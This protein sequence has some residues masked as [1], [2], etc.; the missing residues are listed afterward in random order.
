MKRRLISALIGF[1]FLPLVLCGQEITKIGD[2]T[3]K[4]PPPAGFARLDGAN[5]EMDIFLRQLVPPQKRFLMAMAMPREVAKVKD[6][7]P[8][9]VSRSM[10][11]QTPRMTE[12]QKL[13]AEQFADLRKSVETQFKAGD[14]LGA[15]IE[16]QVN[17]IF[18]KAK[19]PGG[20]K[21]GKMVM[22][23]MDEKT[24]RS[25]NTATLMD[26]KSEGEEAQPVVSALSVLLIRGKL[27][28]LYV[29]ATAKGADDVAWA[30]KTAKAWGEA[31]LAANP[32]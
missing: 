18:E 21:I 9:D 19:V 24:E 10:T 2:V 17:E 5:K 7:N 20:V 11:V 22:L 30:R 25:F 13:S 29:S 32:E 26:A 3:L 6:G 1:G 27:V 8:P 31:V 16:A 28:Y 14:K 4:I 15:G 23:G 12:D